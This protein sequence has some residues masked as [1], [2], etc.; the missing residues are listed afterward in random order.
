MRKHYGKCALCGQECEL[1]FEHIP[2]R[3]AFNSIPSK[4]FSAQEILNRHGKMP[5]DFSGLKY[6]NQQRG[7]GAYTLCSKCNN[8][9]GTW[10]GNDYQEAIMQI[11]GALNELQERE[12]K[13]VKIRINEIYA[14]RFIKQ[15]LSMFCSVNSPEVLQPYSTIDENFDS[16]KY[17]PLLKFVCDSQFAL[18]N[19]VKVFDEIRK[20][21]LNREE[22]GLDKKKVKLCMYL[23][24]HGI[25][26]Q[27]AIL[28]K[29]DVN[30]SEITVAS[31][32]SSFP[33][34]FILYLFPS[35]NHLHTGFD[36]TALADYKYDDLIFMEFPYKLYESNSIITDDFRTKVE[37]KKT[38][39][40]NLK[41]LEMLNHD[42]ENKDI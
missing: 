25:E 28:E 37:I 4:Y 26:K 40:D 42:N 11:A 18:F 20:F 34:G 2:P 38:I 6:T 16:S 31:E 39:N 3:A 1:T 35:D 10:Y 9:T 8:L 12:N 29:M 17:P 21:V 30:N 15:V 7:S 14:L 32:I 33:V 19:S 41:T 36:I 5:W 23:L 22:R 24:D 13:N 27:N